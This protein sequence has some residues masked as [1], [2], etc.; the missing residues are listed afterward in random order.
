MET[1][2]DGRSGAGALAARDIHT[3]SLYEY[4]I[5]VTHTPADSPH[6]PNPQ[7]ACAAPPQPTPPCLVPQRPNPRPAP[8]PQPAHI[9]TPR[10]LLMCET[11]LRREASVPSVFFSMSSSA[12]RGLLQQEA[13]SCGEPQATRFTLGT[14]RVRR[15]PLRI[16]RRSLRGGGGGT[17][18]WRLLRR[19][20]ILV[21]SDSWRESSWR[22]SSWRKSSWRE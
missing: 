22:E 1:G 6:H 20:C 10:S 9:R 11:L 19:Y 7:P 14:T 16:S 2:R 5:L 8:V 3:C 17:V 12:V 21:P 18:L 15:V 13:S 4:Q